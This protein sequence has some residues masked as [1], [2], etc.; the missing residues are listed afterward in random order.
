MNN[1]RSFILIAGVLGAS[2]TAATAQAAIIATMEEVGSDIVVSGDGTV[3][4]TDLTFINVTSVN[5]GM[6]PES[7]AIG[8]GADPS[9]GQAVDKY[10][11]ITPPGVFGTGTGMMASSGTG[12]RFVV[13]PNEILVPDGYISGDFLEFSNTYDNASFATAGITP[14]TYVWTW[15]SGMNEDSFTLIITPAPG[16]TALLGLGG[17]LLAR[18]RR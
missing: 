7:P 4:L 8:F 10:G 14:G 11:S 13:F 3:N 16:S 18:R 17:L 12:D 5:V 15:G 1:I 6:T 9:D 2:L